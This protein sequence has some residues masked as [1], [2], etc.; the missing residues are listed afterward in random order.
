[1]RQPDDEDQPD[2]PW[3]GAARDLGTASGM[4]AILVVM[5]SV[6]A[7]VI[8]RMVSRPGDPATSGWFF[9]G[10][11]AIMG[12]AYAARSLSRGF[13]FRFKSLF[14]V[15]AIASIYLA[16]LGPALR[17]GAFRFGD[18]AVCYCFCFL[19]TFLGQRLVRLVTPKPSFEWN[20]GPAELEIVGPPRWGVHVGWA[21]SVAALAGA[22]VAI[23]TDAD[24]RSLI[25]GATAAT[26]IGG[27]W[28]AHQLSVVRFRS[29]G[30][31]A[32]GLRFADDTVRW[33]LIDTPGG[34]RLFGQSHD[35]HS[36]PAY[37]DWWPVIPKDRL[38]EVRAFLAEKQ[39]RETT[40]G[41]DE[42]E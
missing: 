10:V 27:H 18:L 37:V 7:W 36:E 28:S 1:M 32:L 33:R 5:A 30:I 4:T 19:P 6:A 16:A 3:K 35:D 14:A 2:N 15:L 41:T 20:V 34:V 42:H 40:D 12:A 29:N 24:I 17:E 23:A 11:G 38:E 8:S 9:A 39:G 22:C 31:Q 25:V 21:L 13:R 26:A